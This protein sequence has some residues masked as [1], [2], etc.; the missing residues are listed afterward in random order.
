[1][2]PKEKQEISKTIAKAIGWQDLRIDFDGG[3]YC[4]IGVPPGKPINTDTYQH[5]DLYPISSDTDFWQAVDVIC[6][7][8]YSFVSSN[9]LGEYEVRLYIADKSY[10]EDDWYSTCLE[11][12]CLALIKFIKKEN[13]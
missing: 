4:L 10:G 5:C 8:D 11:A 3:Q 1:M 13:K 7:K 9:F 12:S 6:G 2:T